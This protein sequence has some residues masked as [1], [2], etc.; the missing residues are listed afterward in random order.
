MKWYY[1]KR[2]ETP[3]IPHAPAVEVQDLYVMYA[4]NKRMALKGVNLQVS[5]GSRVALVGANGA[6]KSTLLKVCAGLLPVHKGKTLIFGNP[7]NSCRSHV[8]YLPQRS[9]ID[10]RFPIT[11][12][13]LV[14]MGR[15]PH[16]GWFKRMSAE[17]WRIA[18]EMMERLGL[19]ALRDNQ[20]GQLSGG[21]QQ[22]ALFARALTQGAEILL[23]D[24]PLTA[25]DNRTRDIISDLMRDLQAHGKTIIAA[26]HELERLSD[27]FDT[28]LNL[29]DGRESTIPLPNFTPVALRET[30]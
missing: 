27:D 1:S 21:Q 8:A 26:T 15:Y 6:G 3:H 24:E 19:T 16:Q 18:D 11:L 7:I 4:D 23:L 22:R 29:S 9:T 28:T 2:T 25:V 12:R 14:L 20:I 17:D 10:W 13:Q 30:V 5:V